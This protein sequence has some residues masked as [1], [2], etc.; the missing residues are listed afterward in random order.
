MLMSDVR[1]A[2]VRSQ[3]TD[4]LQP[5]L[6]WSC[7]PGRPERSFPQAL[8][9]G[10]QLHHRAGHHC[11]QTPQDERHPEVGFRQ[12]PGGRWRRCRCRGDGVDVRPWRKI[13]R[14]EAGDLWWAEFLFLFRW[15][16]D[17][18]ITRRSLCFCCI[19]DHWNG[20]NCRWSNYLSRLIIK[21]L[22]KII[23]NCQWPWSLHC[24]HCISVWW[25]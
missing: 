8:R 17:R 25:N 4:E 13:R 24:W 3:E 14:E 6:W 11:P 16:G 12:R 23:I 10:R 20:C 1:M 18:M 9:P 15:N 2:F 5:P 21:L 19:H 22:Y 7:P